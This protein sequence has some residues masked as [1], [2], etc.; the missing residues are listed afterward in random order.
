MMW[1]DSK[2]QRQ[3]VRPKHS[4]R[5]GERGFT[6]IE[7]SVALVVLM[8]VAMGAVSA[9]VY[10]ITNNNGANDRELSMGVA[11][12][13][14][15]W[16]RSVT[17]DE[18]TANQTYSYP[19]GGLKATD[20]PVVETTTSGGRPYRITTTITDV[21]TDA[22]T[23]ADGDPKTIKTITVFVRPDGSSG[24]NQATNVTGSVTLISERTL[25]HIGPN[26]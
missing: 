5:S 1:Q 22:N 15:E 3:H 25:L 14:M 13:R 2:Q 17:L 12:K 23:A 26:F 9:F 11:Q 10:A 20:T 8:I 18:T 19:N 21:D 4:K 7:T 24:W 6:L 16:L